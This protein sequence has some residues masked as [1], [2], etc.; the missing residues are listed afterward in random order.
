MWKTDCEASLQIYTFKTDLKHLQM[1]IRL[2]TLKCWRFVPPASVQVRLELISGTAVPVFKVPFKLHNFT[3]RGY[4]GGMLRRGRLAGFVYV[5]D[6]TT[7]LVL[8]ISPPS[9]NW[10]SDEPKLGQVDVEI[11]RWCLGE[12]SSC[13][14]GKRTISLSCRIVAIGVGSSLFDAKPCA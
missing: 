8:V 10:L 6:D 13:S 14:L 4:N 1:R 5:C 7:C 3:D 12:R 11:I 2:K 9:P